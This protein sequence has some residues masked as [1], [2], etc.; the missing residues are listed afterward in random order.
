MITWDGDLRVTGTDLFL[1]ARTPRPWCYISHAHTDHLAHHGVA[2]LTKETAHLAAARANIKSSHCVDYRKPVALS[3]A[4]G[5]TLYPAGHVLGSA[6]LHAEVDGSTLLYTG[7]FKLRKSPTCAP[8]EFPAAKHLVM[9][10]TY[11]LPRFRFPDPASV[12][13]QLVE[14][15]RQA[16]AEGRQPIAFAYALG[17][18]QHIQR[19]L[20]ERGLAVTLHGAVA[21][22][23]DRYEALGV[24]LGPYRRYRAEDFFGP[25]AL[26]PAERGVLIAPPGNTRGPFTTRIEPRWTVML[27]GWGIDPNA[28]YRYGVDEVLP[29]SDHADHGELWEAIDRVNPQVV[30]LQHGFVREFLDE[31][32]SRG[33]DARPAR[34][35]EQLELF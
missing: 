19:V 14:K 27:S 10:C 21:N 1:D 12:E 20:T 2:L 32:R 3:S 15:C 22:V 24:P 18:A 23:S 4:I 7:D 16:L 17:K 31:L 33:L 11:G 35:A 30:W 29:L 9:E 13:D 28:R 34:P 5:V 8:A 25:A 26:P 6:M